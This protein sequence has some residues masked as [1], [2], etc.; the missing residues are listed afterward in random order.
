MRKHDQ[1]FADRENDH[2]DGTWIQYWKRQNVITPIGEIQIP[3]AIRVPKM[4]ANKRQWLIWFE[5]F[6]PVIRT[7]N[8][9]SWDTNKD[10]LMGLVDEFKKR[11]KKVRPYELRF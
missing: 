1:K 6:A 5:R 9:C 10:K 7:H 2:R 8:G 11:S 3:P 4:R